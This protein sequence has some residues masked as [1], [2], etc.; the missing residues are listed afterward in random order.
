[1]S[2]PLGTTYTQR[3]YASEIASSCERFGSMLSVSSRKTMMNYHQLQMMREIYGQA[4]RVIACLGEAADHSN[5]AFETTRLGAEEVLA[6]NTFS[7]QSSGGSNY[8]STFEIASATLVS[9]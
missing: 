9:T 4:N 1:M 6:E 3:C 5:Q 8:Y 7:A 2:F